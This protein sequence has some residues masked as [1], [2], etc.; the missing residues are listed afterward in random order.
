[1]KQGQA[2]ILDIM[3]IPL[4]QGLFALVDGKN[5]ERISKHKWYAEKNGN[6]Y[7]AR[8]WANGRQVRLHQ[9]VFGEVSAGM[10][11]DH[12]N[13]C[14]LD[15]REQNLRA[16][17]HR[18]NLCNTAMSSHNKTGYRGVSFDKNRNKWQATIS[19]K[20]RPTHLGRYIDISDAAIA[21]DKEALEQYGEYAQ[22]NFPKPVAVLGSTTTEKP[23]PYQGEDGQLW[24][25]G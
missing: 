8:R 11:I 17:T 4:T 7:Y 21:Y 1:M 5:F 14:G 10:V 20:G 12:A 22:L 9:E 18:E 13:R 19:V 24:L 23:V 25:W 2:K 16:C 3:A 6:G 15:N